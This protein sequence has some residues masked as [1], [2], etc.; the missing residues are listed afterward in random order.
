VD[1]DPRSEARQFLAL[2]GKTSAGLGFGVNVY[3]HRVLGFQFLLDER[4]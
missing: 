4:T 2:Q 3:P 1:P